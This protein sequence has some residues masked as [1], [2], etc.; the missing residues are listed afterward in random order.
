[1]NFLQYVQYILVLPKEIF[2]M[3][4][5]IHLSVYLSISLFIYLF[6]AFG[7]IVS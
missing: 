2:N 6:M 1:M 3:Y 5:F 4:L 7:I